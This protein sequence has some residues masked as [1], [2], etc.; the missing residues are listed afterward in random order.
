VPVE[1]RYSRSVLVFC[2]N[3]VRPSSRRLIILSSLLVVFYLIA[4]K[5]VVIAVI[6]VFAYIRA[7]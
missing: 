5:A 3:S 6:R 1:V 2:S 7:V 4:L